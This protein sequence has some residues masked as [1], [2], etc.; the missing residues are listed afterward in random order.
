MFDITTEEAITLNEAARIVGAGNNGKPVHLSTVFRWCVKGCRAP[1]GR[2]VRLDAVRVG[3]G[4]R[5]S[6]EALT[7]FVQALTPSLDE[8]T[9]GPRSS[10]ARRR[11]SERAAAQLERAGI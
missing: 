2:R 4:W 9:P 11:A 10:T 5:T 1:G 6:K 3:A 8:P 7:R